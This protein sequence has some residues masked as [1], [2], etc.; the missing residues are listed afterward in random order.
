MFIVFFFYRYSNV[1]A[2]NFALLGDRDK[3]DREK[4]G[5]NEII[6]LTE[7]EIELRKARRRASKMYQVKVTAHLMALQDQKKK[8]E[9]EKRKKEDMKK[10]RVL[11][12]SARVVSEANERKLMS[13]EDK[14]IHQN[15]PLS[16]YVNFK[17]DKDKD[18]DNKIKGERGLIR[19]REKEKD[20]ERE[21]DRERDKEGSPPKQVS[22]EQT[23]AMVARLSY[24]NK[25]TE[26][27]SIITVP[28]RDFA[29]WKRKNCVPLDAQVKE[30]IK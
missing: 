11:I 4:E 13:L 30:K 14:A 12:M 16:V 27:S 18:I 19:E 28:A 22:S 15:V 29:D 2:A 1:A 6:E 20:R 26:E 9:I 17:R 21:R 23:D 3:E 7:E 5:D 10:K 25:G 24:K 8:E